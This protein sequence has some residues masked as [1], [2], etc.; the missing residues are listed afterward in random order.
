MT[1]INVSPKLMLALSLAVALAACGGGGSD[2]PT[3]VQ[4]V[5]QQPVA[6]TT[7][8]ASAAPVS[9][10]GAP[11]LTGNTATDGLNWFNYRRQQLGEQ[12]VVRTTE[13]DAAAQGHSRY[14]QLNDTITHDQT[15]G[16]PGFT[17]AKV[18]DRLTAANYRFV[19]RSFAYSEVISSTADQSGVNAAEELITAIYHRFAIFEPLFRQAGAGSAVSGSGRTYFTVDFTADGLPAALGR[20]NFLVYPANAQVGVPNV[21]NSDFESPDPVP[22]RNQVGYPVSIHAD[23]TSTVVVQSFTIRPRN[24]NPL[25]TTLLQSSTDIHTPASSAAIIPLT[26]LTAG[27]TYDVQFT[28]TVDGVAASRSWSFTTR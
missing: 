28:G 17:G 2:A 6:V 18:A 15:A 4:T 22:D 23:G 13:I 26:V 7:P 14:Q 16:N 9:T 5:T 1:T 11:Q 12:T 24:G 10:P 21:F 27:T 3:A 25:Q 8:V 19:N 20:G